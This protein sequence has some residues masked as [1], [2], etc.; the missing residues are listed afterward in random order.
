MKQVVVVEDCRHLQ[1]AIAESLRQEGYAVLTASNGTEALKV[2]EGSCPD[3]ILSD[4]KMPQMDGYEFIEAVR[5]RRKWMAVPF[6][7]LTAGEQDVLKGRSLGADDFLV[8]PFNINDLLVAVRARLENAQ[9]IRPTLQSEHDQLEQQVIAVSDHEPR[10][11][12]RVTNFADLVLNGALPLDRYALQESLAVIKH[13]TERL[14]RLHGS[15]SS[16]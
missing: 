16:K 12:L 4:I 13:L 7:F 10:T 3:L 8:K 15:S 11:P 14:A 5:A 2:M 9:T 1:T 6:V